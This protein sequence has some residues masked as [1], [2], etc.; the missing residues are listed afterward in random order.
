MS[1][2]AITLKFKMGLFLDEACSWAETLFTDINL[3]SLIP[4][5]DNNFG[6]FLVSDFRKWW[7][8]VQPKNCKRICKQLFRQG[9][10]QINH[11]F[12]Q[13]EPTMHDSHIMQFVHCACIFRGQVSFLHY[14]VAG[15]TMMLFSLQC[16]KLFLALYFVSVHATR[17]RLKLTG[18]K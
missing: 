7:R 8:N 3:P 5:E 13:N 17:L 6:G 14:T 15:A 1:L 11:H 18:N 9:V 10:W 4:D 2:A 12:K 16:D